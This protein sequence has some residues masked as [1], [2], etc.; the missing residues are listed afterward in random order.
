VRRASRARTLPSCCVLGDHLDVAH[1]FESDSVA[2]VLRQRDEH[3]RAV[4]DVLRAFTAIRENR[5]RDHAELVLFDQRSRRQKFRVHVHGVLVV[6]RVLEDD[7][8]FLHSRVGFGFAHHFVDFAPQIRADHDRFTSGEFRLQ[9]RWRQ[10]HIIFFRSLSVDV[11][12]S[13]SYPNP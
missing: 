4:F 10:S 1:H 2:V 7:A 3:L 5:F 13:P 8:V 9:L 6:H 11:V 12:R